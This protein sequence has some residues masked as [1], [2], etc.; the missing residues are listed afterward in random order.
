MTDD[1]DY[2]NWTLEELLVE[3]KRIKKNGT[4]SAVLIGFLIGVAIYGV[5]NKGFGFLHIFI[6]LVLISGIYKNSQKVKESL[7][8]VQ[9]IID[10][11]NTQ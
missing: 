4:L 1:K 10:T 3:E 2:A 6:P 7:K 8:E 11:R 5:A 9:E